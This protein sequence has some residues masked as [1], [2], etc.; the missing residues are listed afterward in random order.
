M[1]GFALGSSFGGALDFVAGLLELLAFVC[2]PGLVLR[3]VHPLLELVD[4][5]E[6]LLLFLLEAF[7]AALDFLAL[8]VGARLLQSGL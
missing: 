4:V 6:H 5:G 7:E 2:H 1:R 8:G 3:P